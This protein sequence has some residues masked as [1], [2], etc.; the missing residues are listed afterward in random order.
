MRNHSWIRNKEYYK[1]SLKKALLFIKECDNSIN[2]I[3]CG[4]CLF[5]ST[6]NNILLHKCK[7]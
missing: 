4:K 1:I 3:L 5:N 7:I 2:T 6:I